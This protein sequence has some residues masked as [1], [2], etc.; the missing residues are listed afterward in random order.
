MSRKGLFVVFEGIDGSGTSTQVHQLEERIEELDKC[1]DVLRTHEPWK[2]KEITK[3]LKED[4][5]AYSGG[6][7]MAELYIRDR[8]DHT[9]ILIRPSLETGTIIL[10]SRY[11]ISTCSFQWVQ[12]VQ[13]HQLLSMHEHRGLLTPDI[14][15]FLD[16][17][18]E[19]AQERIK[20]RRRRL[21]K[22]EKDQEFI[23]KLINNYRTLT[24][25]AQADSRIFGK[26]IR[27]NGYRGIED[28]AEDIYH[29]FR[30]VYD[31]WK[32]D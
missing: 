21:E 5:E 32:S 2:S 27:I 1:Q 10:D 29:E 12:G 25:M 24:Q 23:D 6:L 31:N 16:V 19:I 22:F 14:T 4:S 18:R 9:R 17:P 28:V 7:E 15:F 20:K 30:K 11:K 8:A 3:R 13:L 26:V